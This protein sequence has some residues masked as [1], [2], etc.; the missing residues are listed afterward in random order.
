ME[1][2]GDLSVQG[3]LL[4]TGKVDPDPTDKYEHTPLSLAA[5]AAH[6]A[7]VKLAVKYLVISIIA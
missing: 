7:V 6:G 5:D 2:S 3:K 4:E 1:A